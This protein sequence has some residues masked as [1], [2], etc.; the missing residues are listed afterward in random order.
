MH[1]FNFFS[2]SSSCVRLAFATASS[3]GAREIKKSTLDPSLLFLV[4]LLDFLFSRHLPFVLH[5][6]L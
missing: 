3:D 5:N 1:I 6:F 4:R 2:F